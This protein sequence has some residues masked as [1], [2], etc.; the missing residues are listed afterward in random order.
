MVAFI[1]FWFL[2]LYLGYCADV[3]GIK[4]YTPTKSNKTI[5]NV[6][7]IVLIVLGSLG[8]IS[9]LIL[10]M[11]Q[12]IIQESILYV[13]IDIDIATGFY[14]FFIAWGI[15][16]IKFVPSSVK[17]WQKI[18]KGIG[19]LF[20]CIALYILCFIPSFVKDSEPIGFLVVVSLILLLISIL[21]IRLSRKREPKNIISEGIKQYK[22]TTQ[23]KQDKTDL[24]SRSYNFTE[25]ISINKDNQEKINYTQS[26]KIRSFQQKINLILS[27][28]S[29]IFLIVSIVFFIV[30]LCAYHDEELY[31]CLWLI[32]SLMSSVA[33]SV[34]YYLNQNYIVTKNMK[35]YG[36]TF[37]TSTFIFSISPFYAIVSLIIGTRCTKRVFDNENNGNG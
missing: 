19:Y 7:G 37:I 24:P 31:C 34:W 26:N 14:L 25:S 30:Y 15:Y 33:L 28:I 27:I 2:L 22:D 8:C 20:L 5:R 13:N 3:D 11:A 21:L 10:Y 29:G 36:V 12:D 4:E 9:P 17:K 23:F 16:I 1:L 35:I 18:T 32:F 6:L